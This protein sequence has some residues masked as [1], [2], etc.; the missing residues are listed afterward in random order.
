VAARKSWR[1]AAIEKAIGYK[2]ADKPLL[3]RALT[4]ASVKAGGPSANNERLEFL[5][6]RVLGLVV[7][8]ALWHAE[9]SAREG[10]L[11]RQYNRLVRRETCATVARKIGLGDH[12]LL[13]DSEAASGGRDKD[14]ILADAIEAVLGA[15]FVDGG[16]PPAR[17]VIERLWDDHLSGETT[18]LIDPKSA[19]Q[20]W[21]QGN[22]N[23]L[24]NYR[25]VART[26]PDHAPVFET[27][28]MI[29]GLKPAKGQGPSKRQAEQEAARAILE[30]E[31]LWKPGGDG[32]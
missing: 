14:T 3:K 30:R 27:Q 31:G 10:D 2:F 29:S 20:E 6:D 15:V 28:V 17:D 13:S 9:P 32:E 16:F 8:E 26:G 12:L 11:A 19:L 1:S 18:A 22:G 21:A 4:H 25:E 24:P 7:A 5:G 23:A